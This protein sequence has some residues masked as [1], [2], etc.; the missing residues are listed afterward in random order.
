MKRAVTALLSLLALLVLGIV[1]VAFAVPSDRL[2]TMLEQRLKSTSKENGVAISILD[3]SQLTLFPTIQFDSSLVTIE[4]PATEDTVA[5]RTALEGITV[6]T[7]WWQLATNPRFSIAVD[8]ATFDPLNPSGATTGLD[9]IISRLEFTAFRV[10]VVPTADDL[11]MPILEA[12]LL[13]G[14]LQSQLTIGSGTDESKI[15][16]SGVIDEA[17]ASEVLAVLGSSII[18]SG[19]VDLACI[20]N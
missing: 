8:R 19:F 5:R 1:I 6:T 17:L 9:A 12:R 14:Q 4:T 20:D 18:P 16:S 2:M 7:N 15:S 3:G 10:V 13:G 11:S